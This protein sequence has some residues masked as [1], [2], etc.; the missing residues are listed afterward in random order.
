MSREPSILTADKGGKEWRREERSDI[1]N[2][3]PSS[4][5]PAP[6][7]SASGPVKRAA[8]GGN[9][10]AGGG[11]LLSTRGR[12]GG[13]DTSKGTKEVRPSEKW[14]SA[15]DEDDT[16]EYVRILHRSYG[17][18]VTAVSEMPEQRRARQKQCKTTG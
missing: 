6:P 2:K 16:Y 18:G 17:H 1:M 8:T 4:S 10:T 3:L 11:G 7:A 13:D 5:S 14:R 15:A 9:R 12:T